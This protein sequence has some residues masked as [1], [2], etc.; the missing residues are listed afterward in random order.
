MHKFILFIKSYKADYKV[1]KNLIES[2][3]RYNRDN[4]PVY[5]SVNDLDFNYF[6]ENIDEY[7][8]L[9]KDSEIEKIEIESSWKYQ[10]IIKS[11]VHKLNI[12]ENYLCIDS[13]SEFIKDFYLSDFMYNDNIPYTVI[14]Q[15]KDLFSWSSINYKK[16]KF[17]PKDEFIKDR[18]K[19]MD[20]LNRKGIFY[21]FG[22][23][24]VIWSC[25]VWES[26]EKNYLNNHNYSFSDAIT[27][28]PSEFSWYGEWLLTDKTIDI[29][30]LEP[31]FKVF[32]YKQQYTDFI[33]QG[34]NRTTISEDFLGIVL[35]SNWNTEKKT[36]INKLL[37]K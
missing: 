34:H 37:N 29:Y 16:L 7:I 6:K 36:W 31:L 27:I 25:K 33:K 8:T 20:L 10:Q 13:D 9:I 22:P 12:C 5:V 23:S 2:I 1:F 35:Q 32:H 4:I 21:D 19:I 14:H 15:Q 24:P 3:K 18:K 26:F 11:Q 28:V 30:P 17:N